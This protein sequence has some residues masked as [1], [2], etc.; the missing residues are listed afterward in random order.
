MQKS[1]IILAL[2]LT[3]GTCLMA[4]PVNITIADGQNGNGATSPWKFTPGLGAG[5][6]D[7]ETEPGTITGDQW[8]LEA[9]VYSPGSSTLSVIGSYD[10]KNGQVYS[11]VNY[12]AGAI[13]V[14]GSGDSS[15]TYAYVLDFANNTY[16]LYNSFTTLNPTDISASA[17][18]SINTAT[19]NLLGNG[20]FNYSTGLNDPFGLGLQSGT[21]HNQIDL[22]LGQL[23]PSILADFYAHTTPMC[24]NDDLEGHYSAPDGG[25]T[26]MLLSLGLASLGFVQ[27][28]FR[29]A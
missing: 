18:W 5:H 12:T 15:W 10:F 22:S 14:K 8:D 13:F 17:P 4:A 2:G 23:S 9:F 20:T 1:T 29:L 3:A 27:A 21:G 28:R 25:T 26:L 24:G 19:A 11:G 16:G 7:N 6:E